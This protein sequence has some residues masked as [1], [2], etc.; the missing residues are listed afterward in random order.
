LLGAGRPFAL[1]LVGVAVMVCAMR[2]VRALRGFRQDGFAGAAIARS[3]PLILLVGVAGGFQSVAQDTHLADTL[4]EAASF[5]HAGLLVPFA[6]AAVLKFCQG[7]SL[8]A[9]ITASGLVQPVLASLGLDDS[10]GRAC[11]ALA[12]GAGAMAG[13]FINDGFFWLVVE[14]GR[15]RGGQAVGWVTLGTVFQGGAIVALLEVFKNLM[16]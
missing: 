9:A 5:W 12:V 3:A 4:A 1:L 10:L 15:L 2:P 14:G 11:A 6:V 8:V 13:A 16:Q 7:S